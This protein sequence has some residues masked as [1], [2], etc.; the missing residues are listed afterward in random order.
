MILYPLE[1]DE[2]DDL[3][4][5]QRAEAAGRRFIEN[6]IELLIKYLGEGEF[7][8]REK[9][10]MLLGTALCMRARIRKVPLSLKNLRALESEIADHIREHG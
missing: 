4:T 10:S 9:A 7:S 1:D 6:Q 5:K 3:L 2:R 8:P